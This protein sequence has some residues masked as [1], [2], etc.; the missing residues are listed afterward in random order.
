MS[1]EIKRFRIEVPEADLVDLRERLGRTRWP[2]QIDDTGWTLGTDTAYLRELCDYW[3]NEYDWRAEEK[4]LNAWDHFTTTIDGQNLHFVHARS[5]HENAFPLLI[6][7]GWPGSVNEFMKILPLLTDPEAH[8]GKA[9]DAFHVV[10]PSM[11]GYGFSGPTRERGW[12]PK[13]I[14]EAEIELMRRLG[15]ESY[16]AQGGDWGSMV[17]GQIGL[18][19]PDHCAGIHLNMLIAFPPEGAEMNERE[20]GWAEDSATFQSR[21][22]GY[23]QIQGTKPQTLGVGLNDSPAGLCG[24]IVEK[25][26]TW[27][28]CGGDVESVYSKDEL[29]TNV[30]LYWTTGT[31]NSSIRLYYEVMQG[32]Q[33]IPL[34]RVEVP[35]G[36]AIFPRE[37]YKAPLEWAKVGYNVTHYEVYEKGGHFAAMEQ[38]EVL[39]KD[40]RKFFATLR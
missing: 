30:M 18:L 26:R 33:A 31:I 29:L 24:W 36:V 5:K 1:E 17:T 14:A 12:D 2:D 40:L 4:K 21:E 23:Q 11:P 16:G 7:H 35:T 8:G 28:D 19:D 15:Y 3:Q 27:S 39:A 9:E 20:K 13:R 32:G 10:C 38:P 34:G 6:T 25:F 22:T 37:I